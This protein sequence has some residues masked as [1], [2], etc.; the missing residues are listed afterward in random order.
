MGVLTDIHGDTMVGIKSMD[1]TEILIFNGI[2]SLSVEWEMVFSIWPF[3]TCH[4]DMMENDVHI[5][6]VH[7]PA[8]L[9]SV[10][11][12]LL[13]EGNPKDSADF[14]ADFGGTGHEFSSAVLFSSSEH[15]SDSSIR[16]AQG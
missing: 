3:E 16:I 1:I 4:G 11:T 7:S 12:L 14:G 5:L 2:G 8:H 10:T 9:L 6:Q 13:L 15:G